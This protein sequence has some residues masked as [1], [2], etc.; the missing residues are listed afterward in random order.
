VSNG[1]TRINW[2]IRIAERTLDAA[3]RAEL[4]DILEE[5]VP[6]ALVHLTASVVRVIGANSVCG[7]SEAD[8]QV[9]QHPIAARQSVSQFPYDSGREDVFGGIF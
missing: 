7:F 8:L 2:R 6:D 5:N 4:E 9:T 3:E 1:K